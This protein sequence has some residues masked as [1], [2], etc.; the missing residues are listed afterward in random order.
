MKFR[1]P[2]HHERYFHNLLILY[3]ISVVILYYRVGQTQDC[4]DLG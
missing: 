4:F 3:H 1:S 2:I